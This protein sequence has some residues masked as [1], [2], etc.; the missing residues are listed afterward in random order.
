L[1]YFIRSVHEYPANRAATVEQVAQQI[2]AAGGTAIGVAC[3]VGRRDQVFATV[4]RAADAYG[5]VH[6][7]GRASQQLTQ[8]AQWH[9][10]P[11]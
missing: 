2:R 3:D 7:P 4:R 9:G 5:T 11:S 1:V 10:D 8:A 6:I